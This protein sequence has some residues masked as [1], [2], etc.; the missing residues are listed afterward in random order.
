M[1][2]RAERFAQN[3][4]IHSRLDDRIGTNINGPSL[5]RAPDW[6]ENP[7]GQFYLYFAH[8]QGTFVRLAYADDLHGPWRIYRPGVLELSQ[9]V[10]HSH[11]ASPDLHLDDDRREVRMYFHGCVRDT[12][13]SF[14]ALSSDGLNFRAVGEELGPF[15]IRVFEHNG[16]F[17][18]IG[19][20]DE[21]G[22][23][24]RSRDGRS[25]FQ[26]G[27]MIV[28]RQRHVALLPMQNSLR[29][30][31][32]CIGDMPERIL[33]A[34]MAL[35]GNWR[36]WRP[37]KSATLL[38]PE[39]SYEGIDQPLVPSQGGSVHTPVRQLRDPAIFQED[40]RSYLVYS[41]AGETS[42]AM[43]ELHDT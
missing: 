33:V 7:L 29:L 35:K 19:R 25:K 42:L 16:W 15:Y 36:A 10:C 21:D 34:D 20:R 4:L 41:C 43:A 26:E 30:I 18:A 22:V 12:Q 39:T 32:S 23:L 3:P 24:L 38:E 37:G 9:T 2:L 17:Y 13:R 1:N 5:I 14:L 27:P 40:G 11:I 31:Y 8:H 28:P 6:F